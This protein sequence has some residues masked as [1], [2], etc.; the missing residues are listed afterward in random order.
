MRKTGFKR[1]FTIDKREMKKL[2][3]GFLIVDVVVLTG[4]ITLLSGEWHTGS[5]L[6]CSQCHTIHYGEQGNGDPGG[7]F[8]YLLS[9]STINGLC[10]SC[11]DGSDAST[12]DVL[13]PVTMYQSSGDEHSAAGFFSGTGA[14]SDSAHN[15]AVLD[16]VPL[17]SPAAN[18]ALSC[19][20]CHNV[21]GNGN[22]RNLAYDPDSSGSGTNVIIGTDIFEGT[23]P[24]VPPTPEGSK[25]AYK[26]SNIGYRSNLASWCA[27]CHNLLSANEN[28]AAP[29]HFKRHPSEINLD[30]SDGH[31]DPQH[32]TGGQ[33]LGFGT[34]TGDDIEG[35]PRVRFQEATASD[36]NSAKTV[37]ATNQVF[38]ASCHLAHG[39]EHF[40]CAVWPY[41]EAGA[42]MYSPCQQC[43]N[44]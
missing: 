30:M 4:A 5:S 40:S 10:L 21:H 36:Y 33:G 28:G 8:P 7:P 23:S 2:I 12:P 35:I 20:S 22:Y 3:F 14:A 27:E 43:H 9:H 18:M 11:H 37:T 39:G 42:D 38:C 19:A 17:R 25:S 16:L 31:V 29:A 13:F 1:F 32:W 41:K 34:V 15:L 6:V 24:A 44:Q 26:S